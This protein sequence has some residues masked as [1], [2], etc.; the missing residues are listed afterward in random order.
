MHVQLLWKFSNE[1]TIIKKDKTRHKNKLQSKSLNTALSIVATR[2]IAFQSIEHCSQS[3]YTH[4]Q[5]Q[6]ESLSQQSLTNICQSSLRRSR[7]AFVSP[8]VQSSAP[9]YALFAHVLINAQR[10]SIKA[11]N[12]VIITLN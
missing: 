2:Q 12:Y 5:Q 9:S 8:I 3:H 1:N 10:P 6:D 4:Y 7:Y 11:S